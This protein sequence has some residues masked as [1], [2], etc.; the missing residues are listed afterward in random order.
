MIIKKILN[1]NAVITYDQN[2]EEIIV[3]GKGIAYGKTNG[4]DIDEK[5]IYKKFELK[6]KE[7]KNKLVEFLQEI[8]T[9]YIELSEQIIKYAKSALD[10]KLDDSLY[11]KLT[12][13]IYTS[14][15]RY[16]EG[17]ILKNK[18]LFDVKHFYKKEFEVGLFALEIIKENYGIEMKEDEAG[19]IALHIVSSEIGNDLKEVYEITS[20]IQE[21]IKIITYNFKIEFDSESL[22]Y[23]RLVTHLKFFGQRVFS[24]HKSN[25]EESFANDLLEIIKLKY[26]KSYICTLKIKEYIEE[27]YSYFLEEDEILY[28]TI[29]I[30]KITQIK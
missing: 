13:H 24:Q 8:P 9:E 1:N 28:L 29:H 10:I 30:A 18:L 2:G 23:Y 15:N 19:F 4:Q 12:D 22:S 16:K 17:I 20:F 5:H 6:S 26:V 3:M 27:Q 7:C 14:I 21:I 25:E 11:I